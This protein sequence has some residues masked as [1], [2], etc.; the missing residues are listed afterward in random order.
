MRSWKFAVE[1]D[2]AAN[3][4]ELMRANPPSDFDH[5]EEFE[6]PIPR[7]IPKRL[8]NGSYSQRR[9]TTVRT[10]LV[11]AVGCIVFAPMPFVVTISNYILPLRYLDWIGAG[12]FLIAIVVYLVNLFS[13]GRF[14]Y[15]KTG[16]PIVGRILVPAFQDAGNADLPMF[17]LTAGVEYE[18]PENNAQMFATCVSEDQ[19]GASDVEKFSQDFER[20]EYVTLVAKPDSIESTLKLYGY[21]GLDP[22]REYVLKNGRPV[23]GISPT[24]AL[25]ISFAVLGALGVLMMGIHVVITSIPD[26]G[27]PW[28]FLAAAGGGLISGLVLWFVGRI[29][30]KS[31]E[32]EEPATEGSKVVEQTSTE[33][34]TTEE[35]SK[36]SRA[37]CVQCSWI[38]LWPVRALYA[39]FDA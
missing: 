1:S 35:D 29:R 8:K 11:F 37:N 22:E 4:T 9:R 21:L 38:A 39:E 24:T 30:S 32:G 5:G 31:A 6:A 16:H 20:G 10:L 33:E 2:F 14:V 12:L 3:Q 18:H 25:L 26:G 23:K 27:A 34:S 15:V 7:P 17:R 19:W 36:K 28:K 13:P